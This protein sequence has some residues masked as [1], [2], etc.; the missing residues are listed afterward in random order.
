MS[1]SFS[2]QSRPSKQMDE[3]YQE[4]DDDLDSLIPGLS[5]SVS[6]FCLILS[7]YFSLK[8]INFNVY[9]NFKT[10]IFEIY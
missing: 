4:F 3:I 7:F 6:S 9:V 8:F 2:N 10:N 1:H 5:K